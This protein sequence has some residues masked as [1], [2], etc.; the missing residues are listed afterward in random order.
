MN[1]QESKWCFVQNNF[2]KFYPTYFTSKNVLA[3]EIS[4]MAVSFS[5]S[6]NVGINMPQSKIF[7]LDCQLIFPPQLRWRYPVLPTLKCSFVPLFLV[8][9][10]FSF[11]FFIACTSQLRYSFSFI[12]HCTYTPMLFLPFLVLQDFNRPFKDQENPS[13]PWQAPLVIPSI[14]VEVGPKHVDTA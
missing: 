5:I 12:S 13:V 6:E 8:F 10:S 4:Q 2:V 11:F 1:W 14:W 3:C 7:L 9:F